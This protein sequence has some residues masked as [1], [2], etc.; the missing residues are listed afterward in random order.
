MGL[1]IIADM[2]SLGDSSASTL[3]ADGLLL[4]ILQPWPLSQS[5]YSYPADHRTSPPTCGTAILNSN[6]SK[7]ELISNVRLFSVPQPSVD[8][9][10]KL[11][12]NFDFSYSL[13]SNQLQSVSPFSYLSFTASSL[14]LHCPKSDRPSAG[15]T[16]AI[17][18]RSPCCPRPLSSISASPVPS[19]AIVL[20][21][22][23]FTS[24]VLCLIL[25]KKNSYHP[26]WNT[27]QSQLL[28]CNHEVT[29]KISFV[30]R[31]TG[32][33]NGRDLECWHH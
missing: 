30:P 1:R 25:K 17:I 22:C 10:R 15:R 28:F 20:K 32:Q 11:G 23:C 8:E 21:T 29:F 4:F 26:S 14:L 12:I 33:K 31:M 24:L 2:C 5:S 18:I 9:A 16:W 19:L 13:A 6:V 3:F 27:I 7:P